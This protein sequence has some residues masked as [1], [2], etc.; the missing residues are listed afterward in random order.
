MK[1]I[2]L[3]VLFVPGLLLAQTTHNVTFKVDMNQYYG[4]YG[5]VYVNGTFNVWAGTANPL[6]DTNGD[7]IWEA[8]LPIA[9]DTIEYKFTLDGWTFQEE[10]PPGEPCTVTNSGFTNR[11]LISAVD[12][13]LDVVCYNSCSACP[14]PIQD[15]ID[16][17]VTLDDPMVSNI[18]T[19]F[20]GLLTSVV[21]DP[22]GG[23][24]MVLMANKPVGSQLWAGVTFGDPG[25]FANPVPFTPATS[26]MTAMVYSPDSGIVV[27]LKAE[28]ASNAGISV[29]TD[30]MTTTSNAW[31]TLTFDFTNQSSGTAAIDYNNTYDKLSIFFNFG[32]DGATAGDKT[33]YCDNVMMAAPPYTPSPCGDLFFSEYIEGS[34]NNKALEIYNPTGSPID[35]SN[36]MVYQI[37]NGGSFINPFQPTG[38]IPANG[39]YNMVNDQAVAALTGV[40]DTLL[41]FPS[42]V[43]F[44]GDDAV[45]L[46]KGSDTLD[47][48][49]VPMVD[50]GSDWPVG[51]GSTANHTLVRMTSVDMGETDWAVG[52]TQWDVYPQDTYTDY[53]MHTSSCLANPCVISML[54]FT[55]DFENGFPACWDTTQ[56]AGSVGFLHGDATSLSSALLTFPAHTNFMASNDNACNCDM[57][58]DLLRTPQFDLTNY[59]GQ[60]LELSFE[61]FNNQEYGSYGTVW[62]S[63]NGGPLMF[64]DSMSETL[65]SG[66]W[67]SM[68]LDVSA[69]AGS[70]S[71]VF[72]FKHDDSGPGNWADGVA[73]DDVTVDVGALTSDI[74]FQVDMNAY[75]SAFGYVNVSGTFNN[76]CGDCAQMSDSNGDGVWELTITDI[77][78]GPIEFKYSIDNWA[79]DETLTPGMSC[80]VTNGGFTNRY[81]DVQGDQIIPV[82]CYASCSACPA[83][84]INVDI[85]FRVD[86]DG[87]T[88][89]AYTDVNI[90]GTFNGWCGGCATMTD[91]NND[92]VYE[93]TVSFT[94]I[95]PGDTIEWKYTVDGWTDQESLTDGAP[96]TLTTIDGGNTFI[97][98]M[99]EL[100]SADMTMPVVCWNE[101]GACSIGLE[102]EEGAFNMFPNPTKDQVTLTWNSAAERTIRIIDAQ[103]R[104][105]QV[106]TTSANDTEVTLDVYGLTAGWYTV[107]IE[108][109]SDYQVEQLIIQE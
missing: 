59:A 33:Y 3:F 96:C 77:P 5:T 104:I 89:G 64:L 8:V 52:A 14:S 47:I 66:A 93:I 102:E 40:A 13:V 50:P 67:E 35:L 34:S 46:V 41:A 82:V 51:S 97:N 6:S 83:N 20:G 99:L 109:A 27:R 62:Y 101:C 100:P 4:A 9:D 95:I 2:L 36:Y 22:A 28:D 19:P 26:E 74:T 49:G 81:L 78:N 70:D 16:L 105:V 61:Y 54:P 84:P 86:M 39:T 98:R 29:E 63:M 15:Q 76:W 7:G 44:N 10:F 55:E 65:T 106:W 42:V 17:P 71:V 56:N 23:S 37:T 91:A 94:S 58:N 73:I 43:H 87:Y 38:M 18:V 68:S 75:G 69:T 85:T 60:S 30:A 80:V 92:N 88:G 90:N 108:S 32:V 11:S 21:A 57:S 31:E 53:G 24:N 72:V 1:R 103:G 79:T 12:T 25:G 48:I 107:A 45:L